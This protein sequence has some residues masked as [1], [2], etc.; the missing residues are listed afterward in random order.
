MLLVGRQD[1]VVGPNDAT[2][3]VVAHE[4]AVLGLDGLTPDFTTRTL[5]EL[6]HVDAAAML[7]AWRRW[8]GG[9]W[10]S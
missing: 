9:R 5:A 7:E 6:A 4:A 2:A 1:L 3:Q 10:R 8:S